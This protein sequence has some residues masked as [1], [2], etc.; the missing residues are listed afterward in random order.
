MRTRK[1]ILTTTGGMETEF[2]SV[3]QKNFKDVGDEEEEELCSSNETVGSIAWEEVNKEEFSELD[4]ND[5]ET[6]ET[7]ES[8]RPCA[9]PLKFSSLTPLTTDQISSIFLTAS[10][11]LKSEIS[12]HLPPVLPLEGQIFFFNL[13]HR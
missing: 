9:V 5:N 3:W 12:P 11:K 2:D 13:G 6:N 4:I 8:K 7:N 10:T 1:R